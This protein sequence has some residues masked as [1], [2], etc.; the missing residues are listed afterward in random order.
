MTET[1]TQKTLSRSGLMFLVVL[2]FL[3]WTVS[4]S[5]VQVLSQQ[6]DGPEI[7]IPDLNGDA[8]PEPAIIPA[9]GLPVASLFYRSVLFPNLWF[10]PAPVRLLSY[11][12]L[13]QGPPAPV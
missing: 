7:Q 10:T 4:A 6:F 5:S 8:S 9:T 13:S 11:P 3:V 1:D 12:R 2:A